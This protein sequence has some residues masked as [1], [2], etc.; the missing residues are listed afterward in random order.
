LPAAVAVSVVPAARL[1]EGRFP[2]PDVTAGTVLVTVFLVAA[3]LSPVLLGHVIDHTAV[4][5][6]TLRSVGGRNG[7]RGVILLGHDA[8]LIQREWASP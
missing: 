6:A 4:G 3:G 2:L 8:L 7:S 5:R 1:V